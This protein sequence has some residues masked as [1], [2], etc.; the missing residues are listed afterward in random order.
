MLPIIGKKSGEK[1]YQ[2]I[3][4]KEMKK[5]IETMAKKLQDWQLE[6]H[7]VIKPILKFSDEGVYPLFTLIKMPPDLEKKVKELNKK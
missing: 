2:D 1:L 4:E 7:C 6:N 3:R 5:W